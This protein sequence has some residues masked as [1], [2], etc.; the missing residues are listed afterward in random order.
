[1]SGKPRLCFSCSTAR[2]SER[3][4]FAPKS[5]TVAPSN[6]KSVTPSPDRPPSWI[7]Q[8]SL[9]PR[10]TAKLGQLSRGRG[11]PGLEARLE[12]EELVEGVQTGR[13]LH[14]QLL[15]DDPEAGPGLE[16]DGRPLEGER[17]REL[18][19]HLDLP[20]HAEEPVR[21]QREPGQVEEREREV[22]EHEIDVVAL[23][24]GIEPAEQLLERTPV[25]VQIDASDGQLARGRRIRRETV[26]RVAGPLERLLP[27]V[28]VAQK[29][30]RGHEV[31]VVEPATGHPVEA[32]RPDRD[33][34]GR[35]QHD[36]ELLGDAHLQMDL[37]R[38]LSVES[39]A[40]FEAVTQPGLELLGW[41]RPPA[42]PGQ[43][44]TEQAVRQRRS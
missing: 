27:L 17:L 7:V 42:R 38:R 43:R 19:A 29:A 33:R 44:G 39:E 5:L 24:L 21:R 22:L 41:R 9:T 26:Q 14:H 6:S 4:S 18:G 11:P 35:L 3:P 13:A 20:A 28:M 10:V 2:L 36:V 40:H 32:A 12:E 25:H 31:E 34:Y 1:M 30:R 37:Y 23:A 8:S 15:D 16:N